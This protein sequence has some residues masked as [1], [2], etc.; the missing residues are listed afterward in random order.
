MLDFSSTDLPVPKTVHVVW[1]DKS[2]KAIMDNAKLRYEGTVIGDY[3]VPVA[4]RIPDALLDDLRRD[5]KGNLRI[6][7][8]LKDD[9]V[10]VGWDIERRPGFD[11]K[12]ARDENIHYAA[13]YSF[14]GGDFQERQI[15]NGKIIQKGWYIN[16]N[17]QKIETDY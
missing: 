2:C 5:P 15:K 3:T 8:R 14:V 4:E 13:E 9:G 7:I 1:K 12:R 17:G 10:L 16:K 11:A 6:K